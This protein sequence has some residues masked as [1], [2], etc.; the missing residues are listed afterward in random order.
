MGMGL[1]GEPIKGAGL[2]D[3]AGPR[4]TGLR[5]LFFTRRFTVLTLSTALRY[6]ASEAESMY[7][8]R[9][10]MSGGKRSGDASLLGLGR[11][12][13]MLCVPD[14]MDRRWLTE[15]VQCSSHS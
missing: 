10:D 15:T 8:S 1:C 6:L 9:V 5:L 12:D 2:G 3:P 14:S 13:A 7:T 4:L 11:G